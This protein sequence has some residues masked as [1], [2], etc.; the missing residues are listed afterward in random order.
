MLNFRLTLIL[1]GLNN[2]IL[3]QI[4]LIKSIEL[5]KSV[6]QAVYHPKGNDFAVLHAGKQIHIFDAHN[7]QLNTILDDKGEGDIRIAYS[8]DG[9]YLLAGSWDKTI[10]LWDLSKEKIVRRYYGHEQA[11][12][13]VSFNPQGNIIASAGWDMAIHFW[14]VPT[15]INLKNLTGHSQCVRSI[16]FSPDGSKIATAG[17]DQLLKIWDISSGKE[18]F[19]VKT[20]SFPV[21]VIVF[22]PDG[23]HIATAGLENNVKLWDAKNGTLERVFKGHTDAVYALD[24]SPDGR[25]LVSGGNDNVIRIWDVKT[26]NTLFQLKGHSQGIR[27]LA[28]SPNGKQ[29][30]SGA[31]DKLIKIWDVSSL[32]IVPL[33]QNK[34]SVSYNNPIQINIIAPTQNPYVSTKRILPIS[35]EIKNSDYN[36]VHLFLNKYEYTRFINNKKE[37]VKPMSVKVNHDKNIEINYEIYLDYDQSEIQ[38]VAFKPNSE[39]FIISPE[40]LVSYFDLE[41]YKNNTNLNIL[42]LSVQKYAEKKWNNYLPKDNADKLLNLLKMQ[43]DKLF[44]TVNIRNFNNSEINPE[45]I[46]NFLDSAAIKYTNN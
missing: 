31:V 1:L 29:L 28:F 34:P 44:K 37:I 4:N 3:G 24:F 38:M 7:F 18:L 11:T 16:A 33:S 27:T 40:L 2:L 35:F 41:N 22:S 21:E 43:E 6:I 23:N 36:I 13:S 17:Y 10:K 32:N 9:N 26:G 12:R 45:K 20:S 30:I 5:P 14:Y 15:G 19:S 39:E 42:N 25:Y 46:L 8:P